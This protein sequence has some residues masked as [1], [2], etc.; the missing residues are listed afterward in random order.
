MDM[1]D[2]EMIAIDYDENSAGHGGRRCETQRK[3]NSK[4]C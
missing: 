3:I 2:V 1:Q 4:M